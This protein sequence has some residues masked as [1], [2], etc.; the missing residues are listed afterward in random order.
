[1]IGTSSVNLSTDFNAMHHKV[2]RQMQHTRWADLYRA[3]EVNRLLGYQDRV[4]MTN[5]EKHD[6]NEASN[7]PIYAFFEHWLKR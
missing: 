6:P 3:L 1:M 7:A 4:A 2:S 5:R